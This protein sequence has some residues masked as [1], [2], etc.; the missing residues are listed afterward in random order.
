LISVAR[1]GNDTQLDIGVLEYCIRN[2]LKDKAPHSLVVLDPVEVRIKGLEEKTLN[3]KDKSI[4]YE[5]KLSSKI[6]VDKAD[7]RERDE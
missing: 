7:V 6:Y 5:F 4:P 1:R 2:Y 3:E